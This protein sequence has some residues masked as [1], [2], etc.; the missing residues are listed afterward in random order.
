MRKLTDQHK[1]FAAEVAAGSSFMDAA[2]S[3][4]Y[5]QNSAKFYGSKLA[6][7]PLVRAEIDRIRAKGE[8]VSVG[9]RA[10]ALNIIW[11][12]MQGAE[13][14]EDRA[15]VYRGA[16]LWLKATGQL[17]ER[18]EQV[19]TVVEIDWSSSEGGGDEA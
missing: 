9:S 7:D 12:T 6:A 15:N 10:E 3:A 18:S 16:E 11:R 4:G 14:A 5:S 13:E 1:A 17:V 2:I 8:A 19:S